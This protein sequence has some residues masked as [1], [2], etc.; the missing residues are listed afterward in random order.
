MKN[1]SRGIIKLILFL[2]CILLSNHLVIAQNAKVQRTGKI[3]DDSGKPLAGASVSL[4]GSS[5]AT[6]TNTLGEFTILVNNTNDVLIISFIGYS[7]LEVP[8]G[9]DAA[10]NITMSQTAQSLNSVIVVGYGTQSKRKLT[11]AIGSVTAENITGVAVTGL[12]QALQGRLAGVQVTQNSGEPGGSVS[13]RIRG[14]GSFNAGNEPLYVVDGVPLA[15][16][17]N[18]INPNDIERIDVLK[19]A[20]SAA[21][22]GSRGSNGVVLITTKKG[23]NGKTVINFDGY[24][25]VQSRAKKIELLNGPEFA[26]LAN[27]SLGNANVPANPAWAN[28]ASLPTYDWQDAAFQT[29]PIQSYNL[30]VAGGSERSRNF[31]SI[32]YFNQDGIII[33]SEYKRYSARWNTE[34]DINSRIKVGSNIN[35]TREDRENPT[36]GNGF[37][38]VLENIWQSQPVN[39][40]TASQEGNI[41]E[42]LYGWQGYSHIKKT[43]NINYYPSGIA[44]IIHGY[45]K[46]YDRP[47]TSSQAI[48]SIFG[49]IEILKG[50]KFRSSFNYSFSDNFSSSSNPAVPSEITNWGLFTTPNSAYSESWF[51]SN[52][53]N[54]INSLSYSR[55]LG[56]HNFALIAGTDALKSS[57]RFANVNTTNITN[58]QA[59]ISASQA[60]GRNVSGAPSNSSL[61]S[62]I[63]RLTYDFDDKYLLTANFRRDGSSKFGPGNQYGNFPSASIG[64]RVSEEGFMKSLDFID[65]LK[66]RASY[67][68]VGNQN[69]GDFKFLN[70]YSNDAGFYG[71]TLNDIFVP[72]L[73]A[74]NIGDPNIRWEKS[75][76]TDVG[77]DASF[78]KGM[79]TLSAD[80]Y[81]KE[82]EDLLGA[83][84]VPSYTGIFGSSIFRNGFSMEN[85]G[86]EL[87]V[88]YN[89]NI[90]DLKF[91]LDA[92]FSTLTNRV[93]KLT[94][95]DKSS[96][97]QS[98]SPNA[99]GPYNDGNSQ[100]RTFV[101][102]PVGQFWGYVTDGILQNDADVAASG[103][104]GVSPGDRRY[105]D[106]DK[107]GTIDANDKTV[108]GNGLPGYTYG[109]NLKLG[110][111]A[112]YLSALFTGQGDVQIANINKFY[113][114]NM[115]FNNST[116][117]VNGSKELLNSWRGEGTSNSL[118]RVDYD[119]PTSNRYFSDFNVEN[120]AFFRLRNLQVGYNLPEKLGSKMSLS[121]AR[122]YVAAQNLFT[123][124]KYSGYDPELGSANINGGTNQSPLTIGVDYGRYPISRMFT[125]GISAQF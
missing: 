25:G 71:Y 22:Y 88:G 15:V 125:L 50:L 84:P 121:G 12:D 89:D 92:N 34:Y 117:I 110:Y 69:I 1:L 94:G 35:Y 106:L 107:N 37:S 36:T 124:T 30:S 64:W 5:T 23:R 91:S 102:Q 82:Q 77:F 61:V 114:Y 42:L 21:I 16:S 19:D 100:T 11:G 31:I 111:K 67:G 55:S 60:S 85:K 58:G 40:I 120:G 2:C 122:I 27:L 101:G 4:K 3:T 26:T 9:K 32:G 79:F 7:D 113:L 105:R 39:P 17:L 104:A 99:N 18:S 108:L 80:Y 96:I 66:I 63:G 98:I 115:R 54:W 53:I 70:T 41:N 95:S 13:V 49:D 14:I 78:L 45:D 38:G 52:Q 81:I 8:V 56:K 116:G 20:A 73:Y 65:E 74:N 68:V 72:G 44:N 51:K 10:I 118:P 43:S 86:I 47:A 62:Y 87:S 6:V 83:I 28:P 103:M 57:V 76:Q 29:A 123:L 112:F 93:T 75:I 33:A 119:A 24:V 46:F 97:I 59:S 48:A 109:F 90:G